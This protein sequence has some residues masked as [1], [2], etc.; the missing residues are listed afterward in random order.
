MQL[1]PGKG[2]V[3]PSSPFPAIRQPPALRR[4]QLEVGVNQG[5]G[6]VLENRTLLNGQY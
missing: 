6:K 2:N 1:P 3:P 4:V 5:D